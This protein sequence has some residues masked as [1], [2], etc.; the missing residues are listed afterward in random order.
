VWGSEGE[1]TVRGRLGQDLVFGAEAALEVT[2][3][4]LQ[5]SLVLVDDEQDRQ[6]HLDPLRG[7]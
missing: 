5:R 6:S 1:G 2:A 4:R 7:G 3:E